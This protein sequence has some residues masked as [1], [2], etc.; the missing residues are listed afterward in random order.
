MLSLLSTGTTKATEPY[1]I[2]DKMDN[3]TLKILNLN[4]IEDIAIDA[5]SDQEF[6]EVI[7]ALFFTSCTL[8]LFL[9]R[10]Y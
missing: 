1:K 6:S 3:F 7:D 5:I 8:S 4:K 9:D 10:M 2:G